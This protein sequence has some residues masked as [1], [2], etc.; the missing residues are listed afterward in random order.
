MGPSFGERSRGR[1]SCD[2]DSGLLE[3]NPG[4]RVKSMYNM[5]G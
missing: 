1:N 5:A 3:M 2:S 4:F